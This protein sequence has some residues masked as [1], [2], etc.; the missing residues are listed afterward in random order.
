M[1]CKSYTSC[2]G[3][4]SSS[5]FIFWAVTGPS[6]PCLF[7][8]PGSSLPV[9]SLASFCLSAVSFPAFTFPFWRSASAFFC[10]STASTLFCLGGMKLPAF[11]SLLLPPQPLTNRSSKDQISIAVK[12][13]AVLSFMFAPPEKPLNC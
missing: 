2:R 11:L 6:A 10:C 5:S 8:I 3:V 4:F 9:L 1:G 7:C 13:C 12:N